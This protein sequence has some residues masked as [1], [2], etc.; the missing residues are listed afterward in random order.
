MEG[1][2]YT[3]PQ[4]GMEAPAQQLMQ[5]GQIPSGEQGF[6]QPPPPQQQQDTNGS[7]PATESFAP[8]ANS[9][10]EAGVN[11]CEAA[12]GEVEPEER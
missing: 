4:G 2:G 5:M 8:A 6:Q 9:Q 1:A 12:A 7:Q 3:Q 10:P 11:Q